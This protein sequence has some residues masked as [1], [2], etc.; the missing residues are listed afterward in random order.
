MGLRQVEQQRRIGIQVVRALEFGDRLI[1]PSE[2]VVPQ[3]LRVVLLG[4]GRLVARAERGQR[5]CQGDDHGEENQPGLEGLR[6]MRVHQL[7]LS[8][9]L[10]GNLEIRSPRRG[11]A[12]RRRK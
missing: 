11:L 8:M 10:V 5:R 3:P 6:S 4:L 1:E 2:I 9:C 12:G 7:L